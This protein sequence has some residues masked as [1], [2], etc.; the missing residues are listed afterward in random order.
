MDFK[1]PINNDYL[2]GNIILE[3][4]PH[5]DNFLGTIIDYLSVVCHIA[6]GIPFWV[7]VLT[8]SYLFFNR[9]FC[10]KIALAL[11]STGIINGLLKYF[12]ESPR[13]SGLSSKFASVQ[14]N[15]TETSFGLPSGHSHVS[16]LVWG[17]VFLDAKQ[18][19]VK[20]IALFF[21]LFT[22]FS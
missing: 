6:G 14:E 9:L 10:I 5:P 19:W 13:P 2:F 8:I 18:K 20:A 4:I 21:I 22:P 1:P 3:A 7:G 16:I 15:V 17:I 12:F 11:F